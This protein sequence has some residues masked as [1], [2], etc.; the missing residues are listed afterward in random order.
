MHSNFNKPL[1][2]LN[3]NINVGLRQREIRQQ[4]VNVLVY[5]NFIGFQFY[6]RLLDPIKHLIRHIE[7]KCENAYVLMDT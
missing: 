2:F 3:N 7:V 1:M 5:L 4:G 6:F